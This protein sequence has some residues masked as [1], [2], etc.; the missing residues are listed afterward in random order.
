MDKLVKNGFA[1]LIKT[2]VASMCG[3]YQL[4]YWG[5]ACPMKWVYPAYGIEM[6]KDRGNFEHTDRIVLAMA[7][8]IGELEIKLLDLCLEKWGGDKCQKSHG[9]TQRQ[10]G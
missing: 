10:A 5:C 3:K 9:L 2:N 8:S 4:H 7:D 1:W 6:I